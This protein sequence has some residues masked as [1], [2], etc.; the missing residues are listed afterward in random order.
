MGPAGRPSGRD[1]PGAP[2]S[3]A[4]DGHEAA[5]AAL[6]GDYDLILMDLQMPEMGGAEATAVIRQ[7]GGGRGQVPII[8]LTAHAMTEVREEILAPGM[9]DLVT[10]PTDP[11][12]SAAVIQQWSDGRD[13]GRKARRSSPAATK[14]G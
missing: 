4:A 2:L 6:S 12:E 13:H 14:A 5:T 11:R 3:L 7:A 10:K 9:Q 8:A 1:R